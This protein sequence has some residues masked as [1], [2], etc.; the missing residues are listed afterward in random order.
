MINIIKGTQIKHQEYSKSNKDNEKDNSSNEPEVS[1]KITDPEF[2]KIYGELISIRFYIA[3]KD[4]P[5]SSLDETF[6]NL[7]TKNTNNFNE[8]ALTIENQI[9][10]IRTNFFIQTFVSNGNELQRLYNMGFLPENIKTIIQ[11][12]ENWTLS[13][14]ECILNFE[15]L[16]TVC[17][18]MQ[19]SPLRALHVQQYLSGVADLL[20]FILSAPPLFQINQQM[21]ST[22]RDLQKTIDYVMEFSQK[23]LQNSFS[24][25]DTNNYNY[26]INN[27]NLESYD[28]AVSQAHR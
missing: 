15:D 28:K 27:Y 6:I 3:N 11:I 26:F 8:L 14:H 20:L 21:K 22:A 23:S 10:A 13:L 24:K 4:F 1:D 18:L 7:I 12:G 5:A 17:S 19:K 9:N 25:I 16:K 2:L